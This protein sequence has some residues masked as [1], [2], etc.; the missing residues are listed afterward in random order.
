HSTSCLET[1]ASRNQSRQGNRRLLP[2]QILC[3]VLRGGRL[4]ARPWLQRAAIGRRS[5]RV[6]CCRFPD[7]NWNRRPTREVGGAKIAGIKLRAIKNGPLSGPPDPGVKGR[8]G[9]SL[10]T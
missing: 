10:Q 2:W 1:A 3:A 7:Q 9:P 5:T 6:A 8:F 4:A